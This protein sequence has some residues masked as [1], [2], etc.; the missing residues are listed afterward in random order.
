MF[1]ELK[2]VPLILAILLTF[3]V[4]PTIG[5]A[6]LHL[7]C[8]IL[9]IQTRYVRCWVAYFV[10]IF[11]SGLISVIIFIFTVKDGQFP[12]YVF[13]LTFV[14]AILIHFVLVPIVLQIRW[15][16]ALL[17]HAMALGMFTVML[18][19]ATVPLILDLRKKAQ[20]AKAAADKELARANMANTAAALKD[21]GAVF[22]YEENDTNRS[23]VAAGLTSSKVTDA[24]LKHIKD[25]K[26]P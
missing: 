11:I 7:S 12:G 25:L 16:K 10:S 5:A 18:G 19:L 2:I 9:R 20:A 23:L 13:P 24:D 1:A 4:I 15:G 3:V 26:K 21:L 22:T 8:K 14:L 6:C 17:A